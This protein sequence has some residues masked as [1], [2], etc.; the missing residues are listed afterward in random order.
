MFCDFE[1]KRR[2]FINGVM[3]TIF[4][5]LNVTEWRHTYC[6][7]ITDL[8]FLIL[9][10]NI[11]T[12]PKANTERYSLIETIQIENNAIIFKEVNLLSS[13][14]ITF[15]RLIDVRE[16]EWFWKDLLSTSGH[17]KVVTAR[18]CKLGR[19]EGFK[20]F[21]NVL[22]HEW[23]CSNNVQYLRWIFYCD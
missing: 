20:W 1:F 17:K 6:D 12:V 23:F 22:T 8:L 21:F 2:S 16:G 4:W 13:R 11:K 14:K 18:P 10:R 7:Q 19:H 5:K 15:I 3:H 9:W